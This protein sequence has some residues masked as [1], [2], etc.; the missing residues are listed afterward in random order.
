[1]KRLSCSD[2]R[3]IGD[4]KFKSQKIQAAIALKLGIPKSTV[5]DALRDIAHACCSTPWDEL[6]ELPDAELLARIRPDSV[7]KKLQP[8][9]QLLVE[10][11]MNS[12][13]TLD[14]VMQQYYYKQPLPA[15]MDYYSP[16]TVYKMVNDWTEAN[17]GRKAVADIPPTAPGEVLEI[18]F[19]SAPLCWSDDCLRSHRWHIF[20]ACLS[21]SGLIYAYAFPNKKADSWLQG[22]TNALRFIGGCPMSLWI[23]NAGAPVTRGDRHEDDLSLPLRHLCRHYGMLID[24]RPPRTPKTG[25][26]AETPCCQV[27]RILRARY[28]NAPLKV[29]SEAELNQKILHDVEQ[30]N[31]RPFTDSEVSSSRRCLFELKE[32]QALQ[33]L[34]QQHYEPGSWTYAIASS[35]YYCRVKGQLYMVPNHLAGQRLPIR[36]TNEHVEFYDPKTG[37]QAAVWDRDYSP[38][39]ARHERIEFMT[40]AD[41]AYGRGKEGVQA[42][43][44]VKGFE[45]DALLNIIARLYDAPQFT[46]MLKVSKTK[47]LERMCLKYGEEQTCRYCLEAEAQGYFMD[48][49]FIRRLI[50]NSSSGKN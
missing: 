33:A 20:V 8:D 7:S 3:R 35:A 28:E 4:L 49:A 27:R 14:Q 18:G 17:L 21:F 12:D 10:R 48:F 43:F 32:Q 41:R 46:A 42:R 45:S 1:M 40:E 50:K 37:G 13:L 31:R 16:A 34:P 29:K 26:I 25:S 47:A 19:I 23:D 24:T 9:F 36:V 30:F 15:G 39:L 6:R 2:L 38:E 44:K 11:K 5:G 22:I